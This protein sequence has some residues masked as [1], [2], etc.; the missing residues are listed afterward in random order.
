VTESEVI[1]LSRHH[2]ALIDSAARW[3]GVGG[4]GATATLMRA[5]G[6][7]ALSVGESDGLLNMRLVGGVSTSSH[8]RAHGPFVEQGHIDGL[9]AIDR[10]LLS[11]VFDGIA[12]AAATDISQV[13]AYGRTQPLAFWRRLR[14]WRDEVDARAAKLHA[15]RSLVVTHASLLAARG[16]LVD[17]LYDSSV[18]NGDWARLAGVA[19]VAG[20]DD[21]V[22]KSAHGRW[23]AQSCDTVTGPAGVMWLACVASGKHSGIDLVRRVFSPF[24]PSSYPPAQY[25]GVAWPFWYRLRAVDDGSQR[26]GG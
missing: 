13:A 3:R 12:H 5:I 16:A 1:A 15:S 23:E 26:L 24:R 22:V 4:W 17:S 20:L 9:D 10:H 18:S 2:P 21:V 14:E 7:G 8:P 6:A 11:M 19:V 25:V